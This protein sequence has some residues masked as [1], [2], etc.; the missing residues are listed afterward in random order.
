MIERDYLVQDFAL[1]MLED[2]DAALDI[3]GYFFTWTIKAPQNDEEYSAESNTLADKNTMNFFSRHGN[4]EDIP[5]STD[6][7]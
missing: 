1:V 5:D 3:D 2:T 6:R 7:I 4:Q